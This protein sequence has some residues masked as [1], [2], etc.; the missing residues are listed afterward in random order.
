ME[1]IDGLAHLRA[2][3]GEA[4]KAAAQAFVGAEWWPLASL[5][6]VS[7]C[8]FLCAASDYPTAEKRVF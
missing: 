4:Y 3:L 7:R 6:S 5:A 2:G 8:S 1:R